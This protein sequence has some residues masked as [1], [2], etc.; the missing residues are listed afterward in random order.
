MVNRSTHSYF[1]TDPS[2]P[3]LP[4]SDMSSELENYTLSLA[5]SELFKPVNTMDLT[6]LQ[7]TQYTYDRARAIARAYKMTPQDVVFLTPKFWQLHVDHIAGMDG[8]A[9]TLLAIQ[10]NLAAGTLAPH[11]LARPE[12]HPLLQ[13][14][15][16]FDVSAQFLLTE[17]AHGLDSPNLETTA[18]LLP[19][20]GFSLNTPHLG[21]AKHMSPSAP[22]GGMP[23]VAIVIARLIV[24]GEDRGVRPFVVPLGDGKEMCKGVSAKILPGRA[25]SKPVDHALTYFDH[26]LLPSTALLGKL[27]KPKDLRINFLRVIW[28]VA[29]GSLALSTISIPALKL[30]AYVAGK[31]SLRRTVTGSDGSPIPIISF[32]TQQLPILHTLAQAQVLEAYA[33]TSI[34]WFTDGG[35]DMTVKHGIAAALKAVMLQHVQSSLYQLAER[36]GAQGLYEHNQIIEAQLESRGISIA[37]GDILALCIRLAS[38]LLI[39]R[40][41]LPGT[42]NP[43]SLLARHE[44]GLF[45]EAH[46][47]LRSLGSSHRSEGFNRLVLPLAQPMVEAIGHR[48]A[49]DAAVERGINNDALDLY[50]AGVVKHDASWY[51]EFAGLSRVSIRE[52]EDRAIDKLLP[53]LGELLDWTGV[54]PYCVAPIVSDAAADRFYARLR[55]YAGEASLCLI[56]PVTP[57]AQNRLKAM[58]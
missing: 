40:Y 3:S 56:P 25:G 35:L 11:S 34:E 31:Y 41:S 12:L 14:I 43:S 13:K 1:V 20:G 26:V 49:Y 57:D 47:A 15:M 24:S 48:M 37:E 23:R 53:R 36:C 54:E 17:L 16:D 30:G 38:E 52:M 46:A 10:Y 50:E 33:A 39:G 4:P 21:A 5:R 8:A 44:A 51:V 19:D 42:T 9:F 2:P 18:T 27:D 28:R 45:A 6:F 29:V 22:V 7:R 58:L 55:L 32:R